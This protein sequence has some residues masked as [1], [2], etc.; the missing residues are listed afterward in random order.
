[1]EEKEEKGLSLNLF[2]VS[3]DS[4]VDVVHSFS[5]LNILYYRGLGDVYSPDEPPYNVPCCEQMLGPSDQAR[6]KSSGN[7]SIANLRP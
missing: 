4:F 2:F 5:V 1:M 6:V 7:G 3:L